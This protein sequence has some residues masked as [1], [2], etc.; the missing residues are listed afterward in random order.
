MWLGRTLIHILGPIIRLFMRVRVVGA[1]NIPPQ[2]EPIILC[3]NHISNWDPVLLIVAHPK[4]HVHFMAKAELFCNPLFS[5][6]LGKQLGAFP[7]RRG[8]GDTGVIDTAS[9]ILEEGKIMGIFP[10]GTRSKTGKLLS[11]KSGA[12]L[13]AA[14]TGASVLPAAVVTKNQKIRPFK[15]VT[16]VY[17]TP[18]TPQELQLVDVEKTNLHFAARHIMQ[19]IG[20]LIEAHG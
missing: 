17:G 16:V 9:H 1:E 5:W 18:I 6:F 13:I 8:K 20:E 19:R 11:P 15:R 2:G 4:R 3:S 12:A 14:R 7:V 10:E